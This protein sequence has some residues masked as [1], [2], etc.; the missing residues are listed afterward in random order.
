MEHGQSPGS[1]CESHLGSCL[2][3]LAGE[4]LPL[5]VALVK[6]E[7]SEEDDDQDGKVQDDGPL[8]G[9]RVARFAVADGISR[10]VGLAE[11]TVRTW[12]EMGGSKRCSIVSP[13][14]WLLLPCLGALL[15]SCC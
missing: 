3:V 14:L 4:L 11:E 1:V 10:V 15:D 12:G 13:V 9:R 5:A 2:N 6:Y 8:G 7:P